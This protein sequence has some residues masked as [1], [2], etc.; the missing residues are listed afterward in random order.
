MT[1]TATL[2]RKSVERIVREIVLGGRASAP[3]GDAE[4]GGEHFGAA[5]PSD[6]RARRDA[7][8]QR[9]K[10]DRPEAAVSGRFFRGRADGDGRRPEQAADA[11]DGAR[12][13]SNATSKP[14]RV[15]VYRRD[16][17]G[18]RHS[19]ATQRQ[20]RRHARLCAGRPGGR[21]RAERRRDSRR[22][23]RPHEPGA[24]PGF[25]A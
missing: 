3:P 11:A 14:G 9:A 18:H 6:R 21:R 8:R 16:F 23:T 4:A 15:G 22:A 19:R 20:D 10:A 2:D 13:W 12:S 24:T 1:R 5:L 7:V 25:T 17:A